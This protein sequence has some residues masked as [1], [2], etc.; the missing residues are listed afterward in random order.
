MTSN[1]R[2]SKHFLETVIEH[3]SYSVVKSKEIAGSPR[4]HTSVLGVQG[5]S[6]RPGLVGLPSQSQTWKQGSISMKEVKLTG[7]DSQFH[8]PGHIWSLKMKWV[9]GITFHSGNIKFIL[10]EVAGN[11]VTLSLSL[12]WEPIH[13]WL[14]IKSKHSQYFPQK[15]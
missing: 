14:H 9:R 1:P 13:V 12:S 15:E 6:S 7:I 8:W 11:F 4:E 5:G 10:F 2:N 3:Y